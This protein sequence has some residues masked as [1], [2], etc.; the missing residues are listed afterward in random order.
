[1]RRAKRLKKRSL[2]ED[3]ALSEPYTSRRNTMTKSKIPAA[4]KGPQP[5]DACPSF[6]AE[7][8]NGSVSNQSLKGKPFIFYFYPKDDTPGCT[9]EACAFRDNLPHFKKLKME[10]FGVSKDSLPAHAKFIEKFGLPFPLLSD[11]DGAL[12]NAFGV[13]GEKSMYGKKYMGIERATFLIDA[14]GTIRRSS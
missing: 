7:G 1:M 5:G 9:T 14:E 11:T 2:S 10:V 6:Q 13:W 4:T 12:C 8:T 3:I